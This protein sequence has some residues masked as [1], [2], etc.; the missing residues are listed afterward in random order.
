MRMLK[1]E[2]WLIVKKGELS[3]KEIA[4]LRERYTYKNNRYDILI[5]QGIIKIDVPEYI[6][7]FVEDK[8]YLF[9]PREARHEIVFKD[10]VVRDNTILGRDIDTAHSN[11]DNFK[12]RK[13]YKQKEF[14]EALEDSLENSNSAFGVA[15]CGSGKTIVGTEVIRRLSRSALIIV[16][17]DFLAEQWIDAIKMIMPKATIGKVLQERCD[18]GNDYDIVIA[19]LQS[20]ASKRDYGKEFYD[21]FGLI[22][23]DE[24][25]ILGAMT[26]IHVLPR[27]KAKYRLLLTATPERTDRL[28]N[29]FMEHVCRPSFVLESIGTPL[30][31]YQRKTGIEI[32]EW[33]LVNRW[34]GKTNRGKLIKELALHTERNKWL[35]IK[36]VNAVIAGR[37]VVVLSDNR[38][39]LN[40][41]ERISKNRLPSDVKIVQFVG[42]K[43]TKEKKELEYKRQHLTEY[44]LILATWQM[45]ELGLDVPTL[46]TLIMATPRSKTEQA[47]G[48]ILREK[49]GKH[50]PIVVDPVDENIGFCVGLMYARQREY[51]KLGYKGEFLDLS[52]K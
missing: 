11:L 6:K 4:Y 1:L 22:I 13:K 10:F 21:S 27:F 49:E 20:L 12:P 41:L 18:T 24:A 15:G 36:I 29:L 14:V 9:L 30:R 33:R 28:E 2:G 50:D 7:N 16:H 3:K 23:T 26:W 46:D 17:R 5:K 31:I 34:N 37:Q 25:H 8:K 39:H 44:D 43:G 52:N 40:I 42:A 32:E 48:R 19:S 38:E 45:A 47:I 35:I 51:R